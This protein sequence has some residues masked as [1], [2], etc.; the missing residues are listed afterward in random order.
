[1]TTMQRVERS[2]FK[3][4]ATAFLAK[5]YTPDSSN[6]ALQNEAAWTAALESI[7]TSKGF[8]VQL[9]GERS[10]RAMGE[11]KV[12]SIVIKNTRIMPGDIGRDTRNSVYEPHPT[13]AGKFQKIKPPFD[14]SDFSYDIHLIYSST[15]EYYAL[16]ELLGEVIGRRTYLPMYDNANDKFYIE[17]TN[18]YELPDSNDNIQEKIY[19]YDVKD[20]YE[21]EAVVDSNIS[22]IKEILV[23]IGVV[24]S[25]S[26]I[27]IHNPLAAVE[28]DESIFIDLSGFQFI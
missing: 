10:S 12:A 4:L 24:A 14:S 19:S 16:H 15:K 27:D 13:T 26:D 5:G 22:S 28:T 2:I 3:A 7:K 20:L 8:A 18:Y 1:M 21:F 9:Y 23:E 6:P 11:K 25:N 17:Q